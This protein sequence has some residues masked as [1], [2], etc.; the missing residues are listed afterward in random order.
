M[1]RNTVFANSSV[2]LGGNMF[3]RSLFFVFAAIVMSIAVTGSVHAQT[4]SGTLRGTIKDA[5]GAV[6]PNATVTVLS[7]ETGLERTVVSSEQGNYTFS[8]LP[9]GS[10]VVAATR[11]DF[12]KVTRDNVSVTLNETAVADFKLDPSVTG[13]VTITGEAEPINT[14]NQQIAS[15]LS[16]TQIVERP[17]GNQTNF[18]ALAETFTG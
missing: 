1:A 12:N 14:T 9:I 5:N 11:T 10:Y 8:F 2:H 16:S 13:E 4:V 15:S 6:I 18:L 17:V 7:T 3:K